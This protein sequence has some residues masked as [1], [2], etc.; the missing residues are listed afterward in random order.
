MGVWLNFRKEPES[1]LKRL[2]D[3]FRLGG[4]RPLPELFETAGVKFDFSEQTI[5]PLIDMARRELA[6]L[7]A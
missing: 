7:P 5:K 6:A 2:R 4:T 3:A 1:A